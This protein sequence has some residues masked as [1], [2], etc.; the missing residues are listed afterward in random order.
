MYY[1]RDKVRENGENGERNGNHNVRIQMLYDLSLK[2]EH[3]NIYQR[4]QKLQMMKM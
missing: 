4:T 3:A 2:Y 1:T